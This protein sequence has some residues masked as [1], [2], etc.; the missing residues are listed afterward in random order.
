MSNSHQCGRSYRIGRSR[1]KKQPVANSN[2]AAAC[3]KQRVLTSPLCRHPAG[4]RNGTKRPPDTR[5]SHKSSIFP[6]ARATPGEGTPPPATRITG[7]RGTDRYHVLTRTARATAAQPLDSR[8]VSRVPRVP[9]AS[10]SINGCGLTRPEVRTKRE[11][12]RESLLP[13]PEKS[14]PTPS[15]SQGHR[16]NDQPI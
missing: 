16:H 8:R 7:G 13:N 3:P 10:A 9:H 5:T 11:E 4:R 2:L 1:K 6:G 12:K 14:C 15:R